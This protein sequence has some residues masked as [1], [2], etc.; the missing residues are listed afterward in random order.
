M[1]LSITGAHT[2]CLI[3]GCR[4]TELYAEIERL[5]KELEA[6]YDYNADLDRELDSLKSKDKP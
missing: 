2:E 3:E 6:Q 4:A 5:K 1:T